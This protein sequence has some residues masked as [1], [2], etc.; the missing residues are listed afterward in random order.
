MCRLVTYGF[1][2]KGTKDTKLF[3]SMRSKVFAKSN[4]VPGMSLCFPLFFFVLFVVNT[5]SL[6][7]KGELCF[8]YS[9]P[10]H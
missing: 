4:G 9:V 7:A 3:V 10:S 8:A 5:V 2:T 1:T 6:N